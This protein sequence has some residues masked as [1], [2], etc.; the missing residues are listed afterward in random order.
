MLCQIEIGIRSC[1]AMYLGFAEDTP[2]SASEFTFTGISQFCGGMKNLI[3]PAIQICFWDFVC[4]DVVTARLENRH[5]D[6]FNIV[7]RI[8]QLQRTECIAHHLRI[9][10]SRDLD[11]TTVRVVDDLQCPV[12]D[13]N[14]VRRTEAVRHPS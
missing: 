8:E 6:R 7:Q 13:Q 3:R 10:C 14:A 2:A 5:A 12:C 4:T 1:T 11:P 9:F